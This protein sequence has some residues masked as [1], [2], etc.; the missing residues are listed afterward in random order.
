[1]DNNGNP[2]LL[3]EVKGLNDQLNQNFCG[4]EAR[5]W[6]AA[7]KTFMKKQPTWNSSYKIKNKLLTEIH[8]DETATVRKMDGT[9]AC[10]EV[11][12]GSLCGHTKQRG[13]DASPTLIKKLKENNL[14]FPSKEVGVNYLEAGL[15]SGIHKK[16]FTYFFAYLDEDGNVLVAHVYLESDCVAHVRENGFSP[17]YGWS[18]SDAHRIVVPAR[19]NLETQS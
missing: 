9:D 11:L 2:V 13:I 19:K 18:A 12:F 17:D 10:F 6:L 7:Y 15:I 14:L 5:E 3:S 8:S 16:G 4:P 1:M